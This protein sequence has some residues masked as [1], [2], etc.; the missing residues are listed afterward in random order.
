MT[1]KK[2][3]NIIWN[4][5]NDI[6]DSDT[7]MEELDNALITY[8]ME[9]DGLIGVVQDQKETIQNLKAEITFLHNELMLFDE[10]FSDGL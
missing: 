7:E 9:I 1:N 3:I 10:D 5:I 6:V 2:A 8:E 4:L